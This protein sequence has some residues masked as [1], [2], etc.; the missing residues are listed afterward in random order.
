MTIQ[1]VI[2]IAVIAII[3]IFVAILTT[4]PYQNSERGVIVR[5]KILSEL[6]GEENIFIA[7]QKFYPKNRVDDIVLI[8]KGGITKK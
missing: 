6:C 8:C 5:Y 7:Y 4:I 2:T 1:I 3:G